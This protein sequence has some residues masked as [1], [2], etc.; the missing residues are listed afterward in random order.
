MRIRWQ[1]VLEELAEAFGHYVDLKS[2]SDFL[3]LTIE[4]HFGF[5]KSAVKI[6]SRNID[7]L[8]IEATCGISKKFAS[9]NIA[10]LGK[11]ISGKVAVTGAMSIVNDL[12]NDERTGFFSQIFEKEGVYSLLCL[13]VLTKERIIGV[14]DIYGD[15][16]NYF[17]L[18]DAAKLS[19][20][21][22]FA[23]IFIDIIE[24]RDLL[25]NKAES[26]IYHNRKLEELKS[27]HD[28][29][30]ENIPIGVI[31]TD[32][33]GF[34]L[35]MNR[36]LERMSLQ[37]KNDCL[38]KKWYEVFGFTGP[39]REKLQTSYFTASAQYFPE[40][41]ITRKDG[42]VQPVE[43]QTDVIRDYSGNKTLGVVAICSDITEKKKVEREIEKVERLAAIGKLSAT[44]AHEIRNPLAGI[45]GALQT[46]RKRANGAGHA[47]TVGVLDRIFEEINRLDNVVKRL[48]DLASPGKMT[49]APYS[50]SDVVAD[51]LFFLH[52]SLQQKRI[53]LTEKLDQDL[54]PVYMDKSAIKQVVLNIL[55]NAMNFMP[56]GGELR[57]ETMQIE[58]MDLMDPEIIW[59][60]SNLYLQ[61]GSNNPAKRNGRYVAVMVSDKGV[62]IPLAVIP[63]IFDAFYS[64]YESGTGLGL[65]IS[66]RFV[67]LH[68]GFLG[69]RSREKQG[70]DFYVLLPDRNGKN[71]L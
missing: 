61:P 8:R 7:E 2:Y 42:S 62:G 53:K 59:Y 39:I 45:S 46:I 18:K 40:T 30:L 35:M 23:A 14:V 41:D 31:A 58:N 25:R 13:P 24:E 51:A 21:I 71:S 6:I 67:G 52:K 55:L 70:S 34:V 4:K 64:T 16:A 60:H 20:I 65:Y 12:I 56:N 50:I 48:Q 3:L 36:E 49:F 17:T 26:L 10:E 57:V 54:K 11:G 28:L 47:R 27:F 66:A 38:G 15:T 33:G 29:I 32:A 22:S 5:R 68:N 37:R 19:N 63:K 44:I 1:N 9:W 43:M 69:C